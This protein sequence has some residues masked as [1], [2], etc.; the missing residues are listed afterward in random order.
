MRIAIVS[1]WFAEKMGYAENYL[2]K[3][4]ARLGH[5]V[6]LV[7]SNAQPYFNYSI[8]STSYEPFIGPGIVPCEVKE[9]DGY[10]LHRLPLHMWNGQLRI[11]GLL[12]TLV[13]L[14]PQLVQTFAIPSLSTYEAAFG[15]A[16]LHY[17]L[18]L[19]SHIHASVFPFAGRKLKAKDSLRL[20]PEMILGRLVSLQSEKCYPISI[21]AAEVAIRYYGIE[22]HK[23]SVCPLGVDTELFRPPSDKPSQNERA[24]LRERLGFGP[25]DVVCIY[26]GRFSREKNP[27]LLAQ[28]IAIVRKDNKSFHGLFVGDGPQ[29]EAIRASKGCVVHPFV[30][31]AELPSFYWAADIGIWPRQESTSQLDAA[32]CGLPIII[33]NRVRASERVEGNGLTYQEDNQQDLARQLDALFDSSTRAKLGKTGAK[34]MRENYS[35]F[36]IAENRV[37]DYELSLPR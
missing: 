7:A 30:A 17:K 25:S 18:F 28:A 26:T 10:T 19:E 16:L 27:L 21:D 11:R 8:Y 12:T 9:L 5:E 15:K 3:A 34:K 36:H 23:I 1:D 4:L 20:M 24:R 6:H 35:W 32:A 33:S 29:A 37:R 22:P 31:A 13:A 2:P 14:D